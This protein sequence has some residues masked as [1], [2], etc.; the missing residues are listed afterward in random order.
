MQRLDRGGLDD[1]D[2]LLADD[3][4]F[5]DPFN[6]IR[7]RDAFV[8]IFQSMLNDFNNLSIVVTHCAP[9][10]PSYR[11]GAEI[12]AQTETTTGFIRWRMSGQLVRLKNRD[13]DVTGVSE[14][15]LNDRGEV[16][17]HIDYWDV[18]QGLYESFP[19]IGPILRRLR[20]RLGAH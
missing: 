5:K 14:V 18:A 1:L 11:S 6:D 10:D 2:R 7:G 3:V 9:Q 12:A 19:V 15:R 20:R 17:A 16:V 4:L 13:F 8:K